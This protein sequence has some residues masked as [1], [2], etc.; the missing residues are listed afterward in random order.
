MAVRIMPGRFP[1]FFSMLKTPPPAKKN[2]IAMKTQVMPP[3]LRRLYG[4]S[5]PVG[6]AIGA[7]KPGVNAFVGRAPAAVGAFGKRTVS[8]YSAGP[9]PSRWPHERQNR[10]SFGIGEGPAEYTETERFPN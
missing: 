8:V 10:I 1:A 4:Q 3:S 5:L 9:S 6:R 2:A 7:P